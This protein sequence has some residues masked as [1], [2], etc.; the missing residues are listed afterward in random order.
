MKADGPRLDGAATSAGTEEGRAGRMLH[1]R[2]RT[3]ELHPLPSIKKTGTDQQFFAEP[4]TQV[5]LLYP[6]TALPEP[7]QQD[8]ALP[9]YISMTIL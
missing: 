8:I 5:E 4:T 7:P 6:P 9:L 2:R 3:Q 1:L